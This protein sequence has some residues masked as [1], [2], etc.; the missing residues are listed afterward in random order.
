MLGLEEGKVALVEH[1]PGW[2]RAYQDEARR[3]L[4]ALGNCAMGIEHFGST[5]VPGLR[6][7]PILDIVVGVRGAAVAHYCVRLLSSTAYEYLGTDVV[8]GAHLFGKGTP[9][10]CHLHVVEWGGPGWRDRL[11]FR[12]LLRA[13]RCLAEPYEALKV[14]L[15]RAHDRPS[16]VTMAW[17]KQSLAPALNT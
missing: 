16:A 10:T 15:A 11:L 7:K 9:R 1:D 5:A 8:P 14:A 2:A 6:A 17:A 3:I 4:A 13:D 12:D